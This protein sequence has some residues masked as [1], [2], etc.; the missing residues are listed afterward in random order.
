MSDQ[1]TDVLRAIRGKLGSLPDG[2]RSRASTFTLEDAECLLREIANQGA[3]AERLTA[4]NR[5]MY[6]AFD[7]CDERRAEW[8]RK[9]EAAYDEGIEAAAKVCKDA[10][11]THERHS[12]T[13]DRKAQEQMAFYVEED[14]RLAKA[15]GALTK[16]Q[17]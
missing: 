13:V 15:I 3:E 14:H 12:K 17:S 4:E 6:K 16:E 9:A 5:R 2:C 1:P 7:V 8:A 10:A 11:A